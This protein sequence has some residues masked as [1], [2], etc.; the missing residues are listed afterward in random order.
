MRSTDPAAPS[1]RPAGRAPAP[2]P[3]DAPLPRDATQPPQLAGRAAVAAA[4]AADGQLT[5][6]VH[7]G[8]R[9]PSLPSPLAAGSV[10][11][12]LVDRQRRQCRAGSRGGEASGC[13]CGSGQRRPTVISC[14]RVRR[15]ARLDPAASRQPD[16]ADSADTQKVTARSANRT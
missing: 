11:A 12:P 6:T 3:L 2:P 1:Y 4:A 9:A 16:S 5:E 10:S 8:R 14:E 7:S 13:V 15:R